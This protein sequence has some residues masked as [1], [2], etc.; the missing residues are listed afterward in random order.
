VSTLAPIL[1][2]KEMWMLLGRMEKEVA[3]EGTMGHSLKHKI[4]AT[5]G[6]KLRIWDSE[7]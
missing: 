6:N 1:S 4:I 3:W 5:D 2:D 7:C